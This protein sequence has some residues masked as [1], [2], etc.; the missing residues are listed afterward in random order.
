MSAIGAIAGGLISGVSSLIGGQRTNATNRQIAADATA[1]NVNQADTAYQ[2][3]VADLKAAG[4][5]PVLAAGSGGDPIGAAQTSVVSNALG[6]AMQSGVTNYSALQT[7]RQ[8]D[9]TID[10]VNSST[11]LNAA[12]SAKAVADAT[13]SLSAARLNDANANKAQSGFFGAAGADTGAKYSQYFSSGLDATFNAITDKLKGL[14]TNVHASSGSSAARLSPLPPRSSP[15]DAINS[16]FPPYSSDSLTD[17]SLST[18][19]S[20]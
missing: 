19:F 2:R 18:P 10:N 8:T 17:P 7:S 12:L 20:Q 6:N 1:S 14:I 9:P 4:L 11:N 13:N 3:G 15:S 5:N 16:I